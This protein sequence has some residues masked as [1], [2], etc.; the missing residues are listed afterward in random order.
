MADGAEAAADDG[1]GVGGA[2]EGRGGHPDIMADGPIP[3]RAGGGSAAGAGW[4][5]PLRCLAMS[6]AAPDAVEAS[7][8]PVP[9]EVPN[10]SVAV[11]QDRQPHEASGL[12]VP[13]GRDL[14]RLP[15]DLRLRAHRR[16]A[17][18]Q[19][20]GRLVA[21][22]GAAARRRRRPRRRRSCRRPQV[23]EASGHLANFTDPLVDCTQLQH[24]LPP[25]QARRPRRLPELRRAR[26]R[27]PRP[28]SST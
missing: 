24:P 14:R 17:A 3:A 20:E 11:R 23:W 1:G 27:S 10:D 6:D 4:G 19:R 16:A 2:R 7:P 12:R 28:A 25:R 13:V 8:A 26:T 21:L 9:I 5:R 15:L 18:A 22:D